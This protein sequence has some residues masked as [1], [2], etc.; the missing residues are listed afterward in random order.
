MKFEEGEIV[1]V[2]AGENDH[3]HGG[4]L[5]IVTQI[6]PNPV[7]GVVVADFPIHLIDLDEAEAYEVGFPPDERRVPGGWF[8]EDQLEGVKVFISHDA[9]D[10][11]LAQKVATVLREAGFKDVWDDRSILP[12]DNWAEK[13]SEALKESEAMVVL[14]TPESLESSIV[15]WEIGFALGKESYDK[16]LIPVIVGSPEKLPEHRIPWILRRLKMINLPEQGKDSESLKQIASA[17]K[18]VA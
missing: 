10:A 4:E 17:L 6:N 8:S 5:G 9:R 2:R 13:I 15:N 11:P 12:G 1:R 16:R 3:G 14:L 18:E 7:T